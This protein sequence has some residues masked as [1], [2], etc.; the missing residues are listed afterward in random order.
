MKTILV[1]NVDDMKNYD[2]FILHIWH[3]IYIY[4]AKSNVLISSTPLKKLLCEYIC[5][6]NIIII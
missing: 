5:L 6:K 1:L 3:I 4:I 2:I